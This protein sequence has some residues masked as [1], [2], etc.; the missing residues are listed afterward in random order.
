MASS[1]T[2]AEYLKLILIRIIIGVGRPAPAPAWLRRWSMRPH[3]LHRV[4]DR[5][6]A[7]SGAARIMT[8][9]SLSSLQC[10]SRTVCR[11][12]HWQLTLGFGPA[13]LLVVQGVSVQPAAALRVVTSAW[14]GRGYHRPQPHAAEALLQPRQRG[15]GWSMCSYADTSRRGTGQPA[16]GSAAPAA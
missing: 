4:R 1:H 10:P 5:G 2:N 15:S 16:D 6:R 12:R 11:R 8:G 9:H 13:V 7:A 14:K 3:L